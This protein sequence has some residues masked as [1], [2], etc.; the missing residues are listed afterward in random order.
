MNLIMVT[1]KDTLTQ[2]AI[3]QR[4]ITGHYRNPV[5]V[6]IALQLDDRVTDVDS[7]RDWYF[8]DYLTKTCICR[9]K[10]DFLSVT[11]EQV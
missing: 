3:L 11:I 9:A 2:R 10:H 4:Q 5:E 8:I 7:L 1:Q 6:F